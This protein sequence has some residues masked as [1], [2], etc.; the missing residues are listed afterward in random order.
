[1]TDLS[2]KFVEGNPDLI[3][4]WLAPFG[5]PA[6]LGGKD[7]QGE[8]F[9]AKTDWAL[10]WFGD[11]QR[12]LL[13]Q[14]GLDDAIKIEVVGRIKVEKRAK[15]LWMQ[16]QLDA[17]HE[18]HDEIASL[19]AAKALGASS[20]SL[21]HLVQRASKTGEIL[22]WPLIEG[23]LTPTP[24][25]PDAQMGYS[26]KSTDALAHLAVLG[27][28][29]PDAIKEVEA[30]ADPGPVPDPEPEPD[31]APEAVKEGRRN[32]T[33][34]MT[35]I[36]SAHDAMVALGATC[37]SDNMDETSSATASTKDATA[38]TMPEPAATPTMIGIKASEPV[39]NV[40]LDAMRAQLSAHAIKVARDLLRV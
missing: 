26:V 40:D 19:V 7:L 29:A 30:P 21:A 6:A 33:S 2:V 9:S 11:W 5:G 39:P 27:V 31:P 24:A 18:Y 20:G 16:A 10:E 1:M 25:N 15:G 34:D 37:S 36:Q 23:S 12:P 17:A 8:F 13:Y 3:E 28:A 32:S 35:N 38:A 4:G 14:H 22:R